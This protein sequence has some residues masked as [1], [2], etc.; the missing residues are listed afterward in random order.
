MAG[1]K[2]EASSVD[3]WDLSKLQNDRPQESLQ[4]LW[5]FLE[6]VPVKRPRDRDPLAATTWYALV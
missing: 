2:L 1:L 4:W 5:W 6:C 3:G